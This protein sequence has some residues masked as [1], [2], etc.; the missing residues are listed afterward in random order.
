M[1]RL[2][3]IIASSY[4]VICLVVLALSALIGPLGY[5]PFPL[6]R[7]PARPPVT[8]TIWYST[9]KREWLEAAKQQFAAT[10]PTYNGRPIQVTLRGLGSPEIAQ[11]VADKKWG[12][13][14]PPTAI[15]PAS[16]MW[17]SMFS[18][19]VASAG[20]EA[21]QPLVISPLVVVGWQ[22]RGKALWP[23][24][25]QDFWKDLHDA[26]VNPAGWQ[27]LDSNKEI[28]GSV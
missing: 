9:E 27:A 15:S 24:G 7:A 3:R 22:D 20:A 19:P 23:N 21:S 4:I 11:R 8:V 25:P 16:G 17:L 1:L 18:V 13:D 6:V 5:A 28:W 2:S 26:I 10:N 12:N 14:T